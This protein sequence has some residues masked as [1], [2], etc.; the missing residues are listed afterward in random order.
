MLRCGCLS[1]SSAESL[2]SFDHASDEGVVLG[3]LGQLA[4]AQ[5]IGA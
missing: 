4:S 5:E 3:Y 1:A 2:P